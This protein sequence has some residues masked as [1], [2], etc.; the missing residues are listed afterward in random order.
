MRVCVLHNLFFTC[1]G[2]LQIMN[3][4]TQKFIVFTMQVPGALAVA[5]CVCVLC[6]LVYLHVRLWL[7]QRD[8]WALTVRPPGV[9]ADQLSDV[10]AA[11]F[12]RNVAEAN[13]VRTQ[14]AAAAAQT[15]AAAG[16]PSDTQE[17]GHPA[18][19]PQ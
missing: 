15:N 13:R 5:G 7:V 16:S 18:P 9:P 1:V 6:L 3:T 19:P 2:F 4:T 17:G 8:L 10:V 11:L 12:Q 14:A